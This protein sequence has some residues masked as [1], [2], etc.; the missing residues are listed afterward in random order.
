MAI[1]IFWTDFAK[2]ELRKIFR[3]YRE[4][5]SLQIAQNLVE[6]IVLKTN[7]LEFQSKI[8]QKEELLHDQKQE[9]RYLVFKS[10]KIIYWF[11]KEKKRIEIVDVFDVRQY[12]EKITRS[13]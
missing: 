4:K 6:G 7:S 10:Y 2:K 12:P 3:Y 11:N 13:K 1:K 5:T 8:G 9:F